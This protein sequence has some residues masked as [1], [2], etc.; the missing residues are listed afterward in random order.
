MATDVRPCPVC[1]AAERT[2]AVSAPG[3][4]LDREHPVPLVEYSYYR[5]H[6]CE[7]VYLGELPSP[8]VFATYY[9]S[10]GYHFHGPQ[11]IARHA[12]Q[13]SRFWWTY[14]RVMRP[15]AIRRPG[16]HL[17]FGCG[18][19]DYLAFARSQGWETVGIEYSEESARY[20]RARGFEVVLESQMDDLPDES[21]D[22]ITMNHSLEHVLKPKDVFASVARK[23]RPGGTLSVEVPCL[24]CLEFR[25]FGG[26]YAMISAPL[27]LQFFTDNTMSPDGRPRGRAL[28]PL[29]E[30]SLDGGLLHLELLE[31]LAR[32]SRHFVQPPQADPDLC[33]HVSGNRG[34]VVGHVGAGFQQ[35]RPP[36]FLSEAGGHGSRFLRTCR[37]EGNHVQEVRTPRESQWRPAR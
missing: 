13:L 34:P 9:E 5:C 25:I 20:A 18:P 14:L 12:D 30:Q 8:E 1:G 2:L 37:R 15:L 33:D 23:L 11:K 16:R 24:D 28:G 29:P 31:L 36:L 6:A 26:H 32:R 17:D 22:L 35:H 21:F 4:W 7:T 19:G 27:H 3:E 10:P